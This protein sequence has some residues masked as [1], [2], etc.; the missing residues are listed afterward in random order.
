MYFAKTQHCLIL[1]EALCLDIYKKYGK[2]G[3]R[4]SNYLA[5]EFLPKEC[6]NYYKHGYNY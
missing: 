5:K 6:P 4:L 2:E 3:Y 1:R